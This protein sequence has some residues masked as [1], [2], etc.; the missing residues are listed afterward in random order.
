MS[1]PIPGLHPALNALRRAV[2]P[3]SAI[4]SAKLAKLA[5]SLVVFGAFD[6][7]SPAKLRRIAG[8]GG[9]HMYSTHSDPPFVGSAQP[10]N[11]KV[12]KKFRREKSRKLWRDG[13]LKVRASVGIAQ[14]AERVAQSQTGL[15]L[16]FDDMELVLG[17]STEPVEAPKKV[18]V[19]KVVV[20][21]KPKK[22]VP[23]CA[24][25]E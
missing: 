24:W 17:S 10:I 14:G 19:K 2:R 4:T 11:T 1:I 3:E 12:E 9:S 5:K 20:G 23:L 15:S 13:L 6:V 25:K 8:E 7:P 22:F 18:V 16:V 21:K